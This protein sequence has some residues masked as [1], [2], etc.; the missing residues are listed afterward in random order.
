M[1][2]RRNISINVLFYGLASG[3]LLTN[4][5]ALFK[6]SF[7]G[8]VTVSASD[9]A[10]Q[11][12]A[13]AL[14]SPSISVVSAD[15]LAVDVAAPTVK[16]A[17]QRPYTAAAG[18]QILK[19]DGQSRVRRDGRLIGVLVGPGQ[20]M[21]YTYD[22]VEVSTFRVA[23]ADSPASYAID[24]PDH[25]PYRQPQQPEAV[26]RKTKPV[27]MGQLP[28]GTRQWPSAHTLYLQLPQAMVPGKTYRLSFAN[29]G[30]EDSEFVYTPA[31][32]RSEA[33]HISQLGFRPEDPFKVGYLSTWMGSGGGMDYPDGLGFTLVNRRSGQVAYQGT[34][35]LRRDR[36]QPEDPRGR[37]YT[38][39]EVH[40]L[41]FSDFTQPG[42]YQICVESVG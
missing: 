23:R 32:S 22:E 14:R 40:Q 19:H 33:V 2:N 6:P 25:R 8:L 29:L 12:G 13:Q 5:A 18:D 35:S 27:A 30:L 39:T 28:N 15:M 24:S 4:L 3:L 37:D 17:Q 41:D 7:L 34:A 21:L 20:D 9:L 42:T 11:S 10:K 1:E 26:F 38:L 16:L 31:E 36:S